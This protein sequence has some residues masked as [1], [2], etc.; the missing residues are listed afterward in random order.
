MR[1]REAV[2]ALLETPNYPGLLED[3]RTFL[4][5]D[6]QKM[7]LD[8]DCERI[9]LAVTERIRNCWGGEQLY[10]PKGRLL[11]ISNRDRAIEAEFNGQNTRELRKR[12]A[13]TERHLHRIVS[14]VRAERRNRLTENGKLPVNIGRGDSK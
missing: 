3:L 5:A 9:A 12:Y 2:D 14:R 10:L 7:G 8:K 11:K 13:I 6:L 4:V 1:E